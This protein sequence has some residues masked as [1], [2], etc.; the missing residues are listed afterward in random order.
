[1]LGHILISMDTPAMSPE[2]SRFLNAAFYLWGAVHYTFGQRLYGRAPLW[3][4]P[5]RLYPM[6]AFSRWALFVIFV[7]QAVWQIVRG[8][9]HVRSSQF[10]GFAFLPCLLL[11]VV[12]FLQDR[13]RE[14]ARGV[15]RLPEFPPYKS[16]P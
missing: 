11:L 2:Y 3:P 8:L 7:L 14:R 15:W 13:R 5:W 10:M 16:R 9:Y 1:M 4:C 6:S 12:S